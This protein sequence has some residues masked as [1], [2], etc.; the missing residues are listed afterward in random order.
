[1][2]ERLTVERPQEQPAER[3]AAT[4]RTRPRVQRRLVVGAAKDPLELEADRVADEVM[5]VLR[6]PSTSLAASFGAGQPTRIRRHAGH[7][8]HGEHDGAGPEVGMAGGEI[9]AG[10]ASR[11]ASTSG[12]MPLPADTRARMEHG[13]GASFPSVRIHPD[14]DL[15]RQI[16]AD[17]FTTGT[18]V[19]FAPGQYDPSSTAGERLLAHELTHVVQQGGAGV[20]RHTSSGH[21]QRHSSFEHLM[22]GNVRP[23]DLATVGAWQDAIE[24]TTPTRSGIGKKLLGTG[25]GQQQAQVDVDLGG[26]QQLSISKA[27]I[28]HVLLQEMRRLKEWQ[29]SPPKESS[30][31]QA[32]KTD[33][34]LTKLGKDP[35]F[36]VITVMLPRDSIVASITPVTVSGSSGVPAWT[37]S[38]T[39]RRASPSP[40]SSEPTTIPSTRSWKID[41]TPK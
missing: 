8:H 31:D 19:H 32:N 35:K 17:A 37:C 29:T 24:Q 22:L 28:L 30:A 11:I 21:V 15:P 40:S 7:E 6:S 5:R 39:K 20:A 13:F 33:Q 41:S 10:L 36:E 14:S 38:M 9:S 4:R 25:G 3:A 16:A 34:A 18:H 23:A 27:N 2:T 1:M 12:G 26:G